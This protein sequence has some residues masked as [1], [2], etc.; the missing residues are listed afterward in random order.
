MTVL[1]LNRPR[2]LLTRFERRSP[3]CPLFDRHPTAVRPPFDRRSLAVVVTGGLYSS[4]TPAAVTTRR[5][6]DEG[7]E[8]TQVDY[9]EGF[10]NPRT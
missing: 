10:P 4:Q 2:P 7:G 3:F 8:V 6:Y 5:Q 1:L 9:G